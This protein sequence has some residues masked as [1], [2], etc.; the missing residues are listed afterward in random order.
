MPAG[1][2]IGDHQLFVVDF[3][4]SDIVGSRPSLVV[5]AASRW[6]NTRLP[7]VAAEYARLL[8]TKIIRHKLIERVGLAHD[9]SSSTC[10]LTHRLNRLD[11]EL[12][13]YM[14]FAKKRC[15]KLQ[16]GHI[17]FSPESSLWICW[18]QV[19]QSLLNY[20]AGRIRNRGNLN[21]SAQQCNIVDAF[22][23]SIEEIYYRLKACSKMCDYYW[24]HGHYY[25]R[26][27]LYSQLDAAREREDE[28]AASQILAI[29]TRE[30]DKCFW[31]R[32]TYALGKP[33]GGACFWVQVEEEEDV[34]HE[35]IWDNIHRRRFHLAESA[36]LCQF[37]LRGIFGY[38]AIYQTS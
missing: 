9:R 22:S 25:R 28:E 13:N 4:A 14:R 6:L 31:W 17:P 11:R 37:P 26:K 15:R 36:P 7:G 30:K 29:I 8:E 33:R 2:G 34:L 19:Y 1:Y 27:H 5:R 10:S 12:G 23:I 24:K 16:S 38:N 18:T 21:R 35:A 32:M 3:A 20:H